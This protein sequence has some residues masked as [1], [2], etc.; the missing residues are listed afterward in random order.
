MNGIQL[1]ES[2]LLPDTLVRMGIRHMLRTRLNE[3]AIED[4]EQALES[5]LNMLESWSRGPI[6]VV[7]ELANDQHYEVAPAFF[8]KLMGSRLKYSCG[9][10]PEGTDDLDASEEKML[11]LTCERAGV[12]NGMRILDLGCG[13]G[14]LSLWIAEHYPD[15]QILAVSNSKPQREFILNRCAQQ[16]IDNVHAVTADINNFDAAQSAAPSSIPFDVGSGFDRV[17]SIEMFEHIRNHRLLLSRIAGWLTQEGKLF[18][19]HFSH[20]NTPYPYEARGEGDWMA[21]VFFSGGIMP[22]DDL[23]SHFQD[24]L[25]VERSWR[26]N[27]SHYAKTCNAWLDRIDL[28]RESILSILAEIYGQGNERLWLQRWRIFCLACAELFDFND[29]NEWWVS[30]VLMSR[31]GQ[32]SVQ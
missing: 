15:A 5:K 31:G 6:A 32:G 25:R 13:W 23:L 20:R 11:Q 30:H 21:R 3:I 7:P 12:E 10:W 2:G 8:E 22:S 4:C 19:H 17:I 1:A 24:D 26:V 14:S 28:Q 9:Y 27:G 16:G 18:V 29:G